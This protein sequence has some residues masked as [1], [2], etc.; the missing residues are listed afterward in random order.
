VRLSL[1]ENREK[2]EFLFLKGVSIGPHV[3]IEKPFLKVCEIKRS[4][5]FPEERSHSLGLKYFD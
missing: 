1:L 4:R 5:L 2:D 3:Q